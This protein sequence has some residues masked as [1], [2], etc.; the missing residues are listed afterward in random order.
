[1]RF[2][3]VL[4]ASLMFLPVITLAEDD[5]AESKKDKTLWE[6]TKDVGSK[7][8]EVGK[9]AV[10]SYQK[11]VG[12]IP[13]YREAKST[14]WTGS[15]SYLDTWTLGKLGTA[16]SFQSA[17]YAWDVDYQRGSI[18]LSAVADIGELKEDRLLVVRR[19]YG[20]R[21]TFNWFYGFFYNRFRVEIGDEILS[22]VT[23]GAFPNVDLLEIQTAG[24][25]IGLGSRWQRESGFTFGVDWFQMN[26]PVLTLKEESAILNSDADESD[27]EDVRDTINFFEHFPTFTIGKLYIGKSF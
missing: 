11:S 26:V 24:L 16:L 20:S 7:S 18:G 2:L 27:K 10:K 5:E 8:L 14:S 15:Y 4:T 1:M 25:S 21:S 17:S 23:S 9:K 3:L 13:G 12:R 6:K 19:S 22:K